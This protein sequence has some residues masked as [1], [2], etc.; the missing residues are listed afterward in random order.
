M[1]RKILIVGDYNYG[2]YEEAL[3]DGFKENNWEVSRFEYGKY[4]KSKIK[5]FNF[6]LK[7]ENKFRIGIIN[8]IINKKLKKLL[9]KKDF[10][11]I[12]LYRTAH[13]NLNT[14]KKIKKEKGFKV[15]I[16][17]NDDPFSFKYKKYVWR[18]YFK[19]LSISNRIFCYR[20][21]NINDYN[22]LGYNNTS[23]LL[24]YYWEKKDKFLNI[25][26]NIDIVFIGHFE[27]DGR[28]EYIKL[29][30]DKKYNFKL[31]GSNWEKSRYFKEILKKN[32]PIKEVNK[33]EYNFILNSSKIS[34]VFLSKRNNDKYTRRNFEIPMTK[35]LVLSEYTKELSEK[36]F[37]ENEEIICFK[38]KKEFLEK[39]NYYLKNENKRKLITEK[40]YKKVKKTFSNLNRAREIILEY[41]KCIS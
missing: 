22:K 26:K 31:Y 29:L 25:E 14:I 39:I 38:N 35:S 10:D 37:I 21:K 28:D 3:E 13:I 15:Y 11:L 9:I 5:F 16:F 4:F 36:L 23:L 8:S 24:P 17:H 41:E 18:K 6:F 32:G 1:K 20:E 27:N 12:F 7:A 34:L 2:I 30:L 33:D 19:L 40:A